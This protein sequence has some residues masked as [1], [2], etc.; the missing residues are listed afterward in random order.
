[1]KIF[2]LVSLVLLTLLF[3]SGCAQKTTIKAIKAAKV[4]DK[5]IKYIGVLP[6]DSDNIAQGSQIDSEIS[7]VEIKGKKYFTLVDRTNLKKVMSEKKLNDSGLVN[8]INE[9]EDTGLTEVKTLVT[10]KVNVSSMASS[11]YYETRTD[12]RN[13]VKYSYSKGKRTGCAQYRT[14][15]VSCKANTYSVNT[16][17]KLIKVSNSSTIF[18]KNYDASNKL[19]HC[20][21]DNRVLP[22]KNDYNS[23]L[24]AN[25]AKQLIKDIAPSYV[26]FKVVLFDDPDTEYGAINETILKTGLALIKNKRMEKANSVFRKLNKNTKGQSYVALYDLGVTEEAM[27]NVKRALELYKQAEDISLLTEPQEEISI[28]IRRSEKNLTELNKANKQL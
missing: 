28:A 14:Y 27:G 11:N 13:C 22:T 8:L 21:D 26:Y 16:K 4:S 24:A 23:K 10:G 2:K 25:I 17:V 7:N 15:N 19:T 6:F 3:A 5:D 12:Y 1:M 18:T 9:S 20:V